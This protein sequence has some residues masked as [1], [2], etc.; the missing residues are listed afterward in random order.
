[1]E[2][3]GLKNNT[4]E[5]HISY[6]KVVRHVVPVVIVS[7]LNFC[8]QMVV[9]VYI[10]MRYKLLLL[11]CKYN[12]ERYSFVSSSQ[13]YAFDYTIVNTRARMLYLNWS[14]RIIW[15]LN[16]CIVASNSYVYLHLCVRVAGSAWLYDIFHDIFILFS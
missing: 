3:S 9:I 10:F 15:L 6:E 4:E 16:I 11:F 12:L 8:I 1:M 14:E 5:W 2:A 13:W 7:E